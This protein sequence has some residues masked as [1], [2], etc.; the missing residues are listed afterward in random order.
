MAPDLDP[1]FVRQKSRHTGGANVTTL[2]VEAAA[3]LDDIIGRRASDFDPIGDETAQVI[4]T[5]LFDRIDAG[6]P[7]AAAAAYT[8]LYKRVQADLP[9]VLGLGEH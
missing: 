7:A 9:G 8:D 1:L 4:V 3:A 2:A 6:A 5:R